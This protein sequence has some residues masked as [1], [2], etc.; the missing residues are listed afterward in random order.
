M[1]AG[2]IILVFLVFAGLMMTRRMPAIL[3]VPAMA[4]GVALVARTPMRTILEQVVTNGSARLAGQ[5]LMV[6]AG[7]LL[8]RVVMQTGIAESMIRRAAEFGGDRPLAVGVTMMVAVAWL[9]TTLTGLGAVIMVGGLA[10]PIMM[11]I[12]IPRKLAGILFLLAFALG[13]VFN[14]GMWGFYQGTFGIDPAEIRQFALILATIDGVVLGVFLMIAARRMRYYGAWAVRIEESIEPEDGDRSGRREGVPLI[15]LAVPVIP[16][17]LHAGFGVPVVAAFVIGSVLGVLMTRPRELVRQLSSAAVRGMEDVAPAVI[18][19]I[20]I[21]MLLNAT[22]LPSVKG[23]LG[24]L[25]STVNFGSPLVYVL[26][27]GLLSPL[28]LYRGPLNPY[29]IGIGIF[30]LI[31]DLNLLPPLALLAAVMSLV[32]VQNTC[33][34]T[35]TQN[36]WVSNFVGM[37]VEELTRRTILFKMVVCLLGL[38]VGALIYL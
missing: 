27:F 35:N 11:S 19:M 20:G 4:V 12:G 31:R 13:F 28:A 29:G 26:F 23:A 2:L 30:L 25:I 14:I 38:V 36:V 9:F 33:D 21:G 18:L 34:P 8:G 16:L 1:T 32:Q 7:A 5:Y 22:T 17:V 6:I 3:A 15:A 10:L 24:P 37:R